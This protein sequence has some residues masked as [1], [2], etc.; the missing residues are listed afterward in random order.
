[1]AG[2]VLVRQKPGSAKGMTFMTIEDETDVANLVIWSAVFE[3]PRRLTLSSGMI[4]C[5]GQLQREG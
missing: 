1:M 2:L 5:R 3:K 4:G